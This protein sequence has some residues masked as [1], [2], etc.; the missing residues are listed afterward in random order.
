M[1]GAACLR[2]KGPSNFLS[3]SSLPCH[4]C[5][6]S[7]RIQCGSSVSWILFSFTSLQL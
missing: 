1:D 4:G 5:W 2:I 7:L 6:D 3:R